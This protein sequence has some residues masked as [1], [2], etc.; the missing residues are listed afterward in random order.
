MLWTVLVELIVLHG[1][2]GVEVAVNPAQVT[3]LRPRTSPQEGLFAGGVECMISL[4][5]GKFVTVVETC[6]KVRELLRDANRRPL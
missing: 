6:D 4:A 2:N 5:D 1:S 3:S